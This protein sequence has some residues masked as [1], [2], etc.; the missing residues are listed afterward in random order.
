MSFS[1]TYIFR[2]WVSLCSPPVIIL[3]LVRFLSSRNSCNASCFLLSSASYYIYCL[4]HIFF[5]G[6]GWGTLLPMLGHDEVLRTKLRLSIGKA[7]APSLKVLLLYMLT[8]SGFFYPETPICKSCFLQFLKII[9]L[10]VHE[11]FLKSLI[12]TF[13]LFVSLLNFI[14]FSPNHLDSTSIA[15]HNEHLWN[16]K[17][18]LLGTTFHCVLSRCLHFCHSGNIC[19]FCSKV[20]VCVSWVFFVISDSLPFSSQEI[21]S[22]G[23][24][25]TFLLLILGSHSIK[26]TGFFAPSQHITALY[27]L[28]PDHSSDWSSFMAVISW[29][30]KYL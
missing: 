26:Y 6:G 23:K 9:S 18:W 3:F 16:Y 20:V 14:L 1:Y 30:T 10:T 11:T 24:C 13:C 17:E 27:D 19:P 29:D 12:F 21:P 28:I 7:C 25:F 5:W 2:R 4:S 22:A 8:W 15:I